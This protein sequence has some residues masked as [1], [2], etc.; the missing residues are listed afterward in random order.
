MREYFTI[1]TGT[2]YYDE[3]LEEL[4]QYYNRQSINLYFILI[5]AVLVLLS[6]I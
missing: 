2:P 1:H 6:L 5:G 3:A 4:I